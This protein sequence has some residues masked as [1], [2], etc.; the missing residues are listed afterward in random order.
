MN[1]KT[2]KLLNAL[3]DYLDIKENDVLEDSFSI[4]DAIDNA[5]G[6][7]FI[8]ELNIKLRYI[9]KEELKAFRDE[10]GTAKEG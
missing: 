3:I 7:P 6:E 10:E 1:E 4:S 8:R 2:Q 9:D 5:Y